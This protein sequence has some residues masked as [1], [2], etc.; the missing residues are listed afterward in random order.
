MTLNDKPW[1]NEDG[2]EKT[3]A[4]LKEI[5]KTWGADTWADYIAYLDENEP[6]LQEFFLHENQIKDISE[7]I[8]QVESVFARLKTRGEDGFSKLVRSAVEQL[9]P[10]QRQV[11]KSKYYENLTYKKIGEKLGIAT[12]SV[13][14]HHDRAIAKLKEKLEGILG[15]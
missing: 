14:T 2:S 13:Q 10:R 3:Q 1:L 7:G 6:K 11:I 15:K 12:P 9:P 4:E 8:Q 5:V